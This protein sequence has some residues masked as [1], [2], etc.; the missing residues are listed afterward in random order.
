MMI[1]ILF[2][3]VGIESIRSSLIPSVIYDGNSL[4]GEGIV[5]SCSFTFLSTAV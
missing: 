3:T 4:Y 5:E 2:G 1:T